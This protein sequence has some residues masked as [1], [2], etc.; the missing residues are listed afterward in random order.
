MFK[1][2]WM[3]PACK[4]MG[5]INLKGITSKSSYQVTENPLTGTTDSGFGCE[6]LRKSLALD[7]RA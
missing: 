6:N 1:R 2:I 4:K 5:V 7:V 3:N